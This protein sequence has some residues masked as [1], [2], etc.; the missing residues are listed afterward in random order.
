MELE[1]FKRTSTAAYD[2][3]EYRRA[4]KDA[5]KNTYQAVKTLLGKNRKFTRAELRQMGIS[6]SDLN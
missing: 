4:A 2:T 1:R 5:S 3:D 6:V